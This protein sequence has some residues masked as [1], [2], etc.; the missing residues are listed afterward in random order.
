M[1]VDK[2]EHVK[3]KLEV[4]RSLSSHLFWDVDRG[5]VDLDTHS[6]FVVQRVLEYGLLEDWVA[7]KEYYGRPQ[8]AKIAASLRT[9]D[10]RALTFIA[11]YTGLAKEKFRC[12]SIRQSTPSEG[13]PE[14]FESVT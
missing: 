13:F 1:G 9:L 2:P 7:I 8:L 14:N 5:A 4:M 6:K 11:T 12:Y 10:A 3:D